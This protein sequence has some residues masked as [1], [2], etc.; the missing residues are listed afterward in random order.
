MNI[1][2]HCNVTCDDCLGMSE[3]DYNLLY[4]IYAWTY[5]SSTV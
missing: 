3:S 5:V 4:A 1:P 2:P